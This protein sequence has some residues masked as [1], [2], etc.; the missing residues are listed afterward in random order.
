MTVT[1]TPTVETFER[2]EFKFFAPRAQVEAAMRV[3]EVELQE[4]KTGLM[5]GASQVNTSLYLDSPHFTFLEQHLSG[6]PDRIKLRVRYYGETPHSDC[7]FEIKRRQMAVVMKRR[8]VLPLARAREVLRDLTQ[9]LPVENAALNTF[10]YLALRCQAAPK[11]LVRARRRAFKAV[12]RSLD[13]RLTIDDAMS[14]QPVRSGDP[15]VP[16]PSTWRTMPEGGADRV[17][18]EV[19]FRTT[20]PWWLGTLIGSLA[21]WRVSFSKYVAAAMAARRDPFFTMDAA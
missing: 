16:D 5:P 6:A 12:D 4:D 11:L 15:L 9:P 2:F 18:L 7:F 19:K 3:L 13:T 1:T 8:A 20:R 14:W 21:P 17:L 10:Q